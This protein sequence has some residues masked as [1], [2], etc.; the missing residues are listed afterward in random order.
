MGAICQASFLLNDDALRR[1][2][3]DIQA[4]VRPARVR[5]EQDGHGTP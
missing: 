5:C 1:Q 2:L 4:P 3:V